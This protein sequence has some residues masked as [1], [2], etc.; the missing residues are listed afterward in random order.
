MMAPQDGRDPRAP[1]WN[2]D[3]VRNLWHRMAQAIDAYA[4]TRRF[5]EFDAAALERR[6]VLACKAWCRYPYDPRVMRE[7]NDVAS[8]YLA[9]RLPCPLIRV[10]DHLTRFFSGGAADEVV[11]REPWV[12][13]AVMLD[14]PLSWPVIF[15]PFLNTFLIPNAKR[16]GD[17]WLSTTIARQGGAASADGHGRDE[18]SP[19]A[20]AEPAVEPLPEPAEKPAEGPSRHPGTSRPSRAA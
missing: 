6:Y 14:P 17:G 16:Y 3:L 20:P 1:I 11:A 13:I 5:A 10:V 2:P 15:A 7:V 19:E 9:R 8:E 4:Q 18:A 12:T